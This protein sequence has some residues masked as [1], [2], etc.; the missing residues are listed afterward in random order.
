M[1]SLIAQK[2]LEHMDE[3]G[4]GSIKFKWSSVKCNVSFNSF[5]LAS[6]TSACLTVEIGTLESGISLNMLFSDIVLTSNSC[7]LTI[8]KYSFP[9]LWIILDVNLVFGLAIK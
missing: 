4:S 9:S 7:R 1:S 3:N 5:S 2:N 6:S 8:M